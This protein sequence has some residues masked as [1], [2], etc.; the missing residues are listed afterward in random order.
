MTPF[1][2]D[3]EAGGNT[4][5]LPR[6]SLYSRQE[7]DRVLR[8][9]D[10]GDVVVFQ[11]S[12]ST[13]NARWVCHSKHG[14]MESAKAVNEFLRATKED[15]WVCPLPTFHVGGFGVL[16]RA[17]CCGSKVYELRGDWNPEAYVE[18]C[19]AHQASLSSLVPTQV[20]DL[21][22]H[23]LAA[24]AS[25]RAVLVGGGHLDVELE[26]Q[27]RALGWPVL[28]TYGLSEAGSQ[29]ATQRGEQLELLP[30]LEAATDEYGALKLRGDSMAL[31][32][33]SRAEDGTWAFETLMGEDGWFDTD[34]LVELNGGVLRFIG[35]NSSRVKV[36]GELVDL[37]ALERAFA[38]GLEKSADL[39]LVAVPDA[40]SEHAIVL[41]HTVANDRLA[42]AQSIA[43]FNTK[44]AGF[45]R[46]SRSLEVGALPRGSL[47]KLRRGELRRMAIDAEK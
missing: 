27:A 35:R 38:S 28:R 8:G 34:D 26:L 47:G 18:L 15:V 24:P 9:F 29:V 20:Y 30:H 41:I 13:G 6:H 1:R 2:F 23:R 44:M 31:G 40:R 36:L 39:A 33:L 43:A 32:Y 7:I 37:E 19:E 21:V 11:T 16:A 42:M 14:L 12:G 17:F 22:S 45:E 3:S 10:L 4:I 46:I 25:L 5:L